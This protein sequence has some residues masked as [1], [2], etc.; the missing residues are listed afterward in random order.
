MFI[1]GYETLLE[2]FS[3]PYCGGLSCLLLVCKLLFDKL[4]VLEPLAHHLV[5]EPLTWLDKPYIH[6]YL[7]IFSFLFLYLLESPLG[8]LD[9]IRYE[10]IRYS[11]PYHILPFDS[12]AN[13][14]HG[15]TCLLEHLLIELKCLSIQ[16]LAI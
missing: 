14:V 5:V 9:Y 12:L 15:R 3:I 10:A 4:E 8:D 11:L 16:L 7:L 2:L 6:I 13:Q 1:K